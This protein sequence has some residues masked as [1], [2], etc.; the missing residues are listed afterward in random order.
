MALDKRGI[1]WLPRTLVAEDLAQ[2][3]LVE[4]APQEWRIEMDIRLY[5]D[6]ATLGAAADGFWAA[7]VAASAT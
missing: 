2:G 5:R 6:R 3:R 1:A 4:A 7:V